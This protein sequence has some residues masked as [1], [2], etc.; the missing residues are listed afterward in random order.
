MM[1]I[2]MTHCQPLPSP[3]GSLFRPRLHVMFFSASTELRVTVGQREELP[4]SWQRE[5]CGVLQWHMKEMTVCA[6]VFI[7]SN[8]QDLAFSISGILWL[9]V[10]AT[11][12]QKSCTL[13]SL[14]SYLV[15][16]IMNESNT[17]ISCIQLWATSSQFVNNTSNSLW[18][19]ACHYET[20]LETVRETVII[21]P[22]CP[23]KHG[24]S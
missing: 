7:F 14:W 16:W 1:Y 18:L 22:A 13:I 24:F 15:Q 8:R 11:E 3:A 12:E 20:V 2:L 4:T 6:V 9:S 10:G 17:N 21:Q 5:Y 19:R 23:N